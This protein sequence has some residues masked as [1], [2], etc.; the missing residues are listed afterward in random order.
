[1]RQVDVPESALSE[2]LA[3]GFEI[4]QGG[5]CADRDVPPISGCF[6]VRQ[7][8]NQYEPSAGAVVPAVI[9]RSR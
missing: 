3:A 4:T 1:M 5:R 7:I 9:P 8:P 6:T 2:T